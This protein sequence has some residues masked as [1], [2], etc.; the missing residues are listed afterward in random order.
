MGNEE[1]NITCPVINAAGEGKEV[2]GSWVFRKRVILSRTGVGRQHVI[3]S[4]YLFSRF[5]P[6]KE[7]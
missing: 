1:L 2:D 5:V 6:C 7:E 4:K 3:Y